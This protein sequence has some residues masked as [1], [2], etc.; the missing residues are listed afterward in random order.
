MVAAVAL[1]E[2]DVAD[3]V[4]GSWRPVVA[5]DAGRD[6]RRSRSGRRRCS[7]RRDHRARGALLTWKLR[8]CRSSHGIYADRR[9]IVREVSHAS[10]SARR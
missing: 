1:V 5:T 9:P 7:A 6:G 3:R 8:T 2:L 10:T 4:G